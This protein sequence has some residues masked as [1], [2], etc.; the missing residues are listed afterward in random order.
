MGL[1]PGEKD[2]LGP[3][4][5]GGGRLSAGPKFVGPSRVSTRGGHGSDPQRVGPKGVVPRGEWE[6]SGWLTQGCGT[7]WVALDGRPQ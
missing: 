7:M 4:G 5:E 6:G 3:W 1:A 2:G